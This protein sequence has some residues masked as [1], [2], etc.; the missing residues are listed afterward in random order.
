MFVPLA[1]VLHRQQDVVAFWRKNICPDSEGEKQAAA[2]AHVCCTTAISMEKPRFSQFLIAV[3]F[4][5]FQI[6]N[7]YFQY[8]L[9]AFEYF[10]ITLQIKK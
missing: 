2:N 4:L 7:A 6:Q 9:I 5:V 3:G 10:Y 8:L 1:S